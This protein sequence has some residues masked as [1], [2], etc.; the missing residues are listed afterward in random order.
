VRAR[1]SAGFGATLVLL[2]AAGALGVVA[3]RAQGAQGAAALAALHEHYD[4][5]Q[6][7]GSGVLR[8]IVAGS[9]YAETGAE[10]DA[11]RY[12]AAMAAADALR[13]DAIAGR[14]LSDAERARLETVGRLQSAVEARLTMVRAS[15]ALGRAADADAELARVGDDVARV[16]HELRQ[17]RAAAAARAAAGEA[18]VQAATR[19]AE[20][21]LIGLLV[22]ALAVAAWAAA[23]TARAVTRPL[24]VLGDAMAAI[25]AGDLR[26]A[27]RHAPA[28]AGLPPRTLAGW[29]DGERPAAEYAALGAEVGRARE[30]L[31]GVLARVQA[32]S[33]QVTAAAGELAA[34]AIGTAAAT[35]HVTGAVVE[36]SE[37]AALQ[38]A[39]LDDATAAVGALAARGDAIGDAA[40][41]AERAGRE[42]RA[43]AHAARSRIG[44]AV[45]LLLGAREVADAGVREMGALREAAGVAD[46]FA[47][48]IREIAAQTHLLALNAALEAARA[49]TAGRGFAVVADEVRALAEQS[50]TAAEEVAGNVQRVRARVAGVVAAADAGAARL[51]DAESVAAGAQEAL[52]RVDAAAAR[53][54]A[55]SARVAGAVAESRTAAGEAGAAITRSHDAAARHAASAELVAAAT[56]QTA[57]SVEEVSATAEQLAGGAAAV[58]ELIGGFRT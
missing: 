7:V 31:R 37:G 17:L 42:I 19:R 21:G 57:A 16:E 25:G 14:G 2:A 39:A 54:A 8:E 34:N 9:R 4:T 52:A 26:D 49:G 3:L 18:A 50:A 1:L 6:Q 5:V 33:E 20:T 41:D 45:D 51:R 13:R 48:V 11:R 10:P 40:L 28:R 35:Q 47:A 27:P 56:E 15:R 44:R 58:R 24:A 36:I 12:R 55:A 46:G 43:T 22:A 30:R 23:A 38:L 53:V 32:E 29:L